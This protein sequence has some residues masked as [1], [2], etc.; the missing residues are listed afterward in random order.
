[1]DLVFFGT[2]PKS[3]VDDDDIKKK[4]RGKTRNWIRKR[5]QK[6]FHTNIFE[7]LRLEDTGAYKEMM[8]IDYDSFL[9][10]L[11]YIEPHI[12]PTESYRGAKTIRADER[13]V[14]TI[15]FLAT[16]E[17]FRSLSFQCRIGSNTI[18]YI[19]YTTLLRE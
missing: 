18:P 15:R 8:R 9:T 2:I 5:N 7:E 11:N 1:M 16:G 3:L 14:L 10:I 19:H 13:L 17:T 12:S 4:K 6:G